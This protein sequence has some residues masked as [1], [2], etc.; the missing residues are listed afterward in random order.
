MAE[1]G[2]K[3]ATSPAREVIQ[4]KLSLIQQR[5]SF[6]SDNGSIR[7]SKEQSPEI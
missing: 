7:S 2:E 1:E 5:Q 3:Q 4:C 6:A